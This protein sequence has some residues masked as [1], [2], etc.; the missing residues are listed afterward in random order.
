MSRWTVTRLGDAVKD[1]YSIA[2]EALQ[3]FDDTIWETYIRRIGA[4]NVRCVW[5]GPQMVGGLAFYRMGQWYG[6]ENI[7]CAGVSGVAI[8]PAARGGG[9]CK[10]L[11][12]A[13]LIELHEERMPLACL[14]ASTQ[15]LYR[16]VGFEQSGHR[17]DYSIKMD[18]L[19]DSIS[20]CQLPVHRYVDDPPLELLNSLTDA[21]AS[22]CNGNLRRT[23]GMWERIFFPFGETTSSY[24]LGDLQSPEG[25][26]T[27]QHGKRSA[28]YPQPLVASEWAALTPAAMQRMIGLVLNHR[29]MCHCFRWSGGPQD[30]LLLAASEEHYESMTQLHTLSRIVSLPEALQKRG[31]PPSTSGELHLKIRD[32]LLEGNQGNWVLQVESGEAAVT[33]GGRGALQMDI[34]SLVPLFTSMFTC[35]QL[36]AS[37]HVQC[38]DVNQIALADSLFA[39]PAPWTYELF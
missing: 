33:R 36:V 28:G 27:L 25:F 12:I 11:L 16:G 21:R 24:I 38:Q 3:Y 23:N 17:I 6:G 7:A 15:R 20:D 39:G 26:I 5:D 22:Q 4:D 8:D 34:Q 37:G 32:D 1:Y 10:S 31:Y 2:G 9:A 19:S 30:A 13:T 29:S 18:S 14:Y 35:G